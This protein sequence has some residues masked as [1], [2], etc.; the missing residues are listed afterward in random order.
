MGEVLRDLGNAA[1]RPD[2]ATAGKQLLAEMKTMR[3]DLQLAY[4]RTH[5]PKGDGQYNASCWPYVA[6]A[7]YCGELKAVRQYNS[8]QYQRGLPESM[9]SGFVAKE[10][11]VDELA[12]VGVAHSP[13]IPNSGCSGMM[14]LG[15]LA[16]QTFTSHG[17]G[18]GCKFASNP[19]VACGV[20]VFSDRWLVMI[21]LQHDL[22]PEFLLQ[23]YSFSAHGTDYFIYYVSVLLWM[24][25]C[26]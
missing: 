13:S 12:C 3:A 8:G 22:L 16:G 11:V 23:F 15:T 5:L 21:V 25:V 24:D 26:D 6:G 4:T 17:F 7:K 18:F 14:R 9:Y 20:W 19:P 2:L 10:L 1:G